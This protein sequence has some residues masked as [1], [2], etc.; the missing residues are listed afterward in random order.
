VASAGQVYAQLNGKQDESVP[1][2]VRSLAG[3]TRQATLVPHLEPDTIPMADRHLL[4]NGLLLRLQDMLQEAK[5]QGTAT[6]VRL[7]LA[8]VEMRLGRWPEAARNL[9]QLKLPEGSGVS[10]G[11]IA[12]L[13]G[14]CYE[15]LGRTAESNAAFTAAAKSPDSMLSL[16]GPRTAPLAQEKLS[17]R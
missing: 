12:Y 15:A 2:T 16:R 3:M 10:A 6:A 7:N 1:I 4:Y 5:S 14:V 11:T 9:E 8:I 17:P 13:T